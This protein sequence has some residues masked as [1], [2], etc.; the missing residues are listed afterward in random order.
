[1][2]CVFQNISHSEQQYSS[3]N[4]SCFHLNTSKSFLKKLLKILTSLKYCLDCHEESVW[5]WYVLWY[6]LKF[7]FAQSSGHVEILYFW[8]NAPKTN[9]IQTMKFSLLLPATQRLSFLLLL[10]RN[11]GT[12]SSW[13][14]VHFFFFFHS[15]FFGDEFSPKMQR[16]VWSRIFWISCCFF[17]IEFLVLNKNGQASFMISR[18]F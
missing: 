17:A 3:E 15:V 14:D 11:I 7:L 18:E 1:M 5:L 12:S 13:L 4:I 8:T 9:C 16:Q 6:Y 10:F 2:K